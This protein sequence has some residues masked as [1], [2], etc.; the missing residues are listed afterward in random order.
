MKSLAVNVQSHEDMKK[1][2][3]YIISNYVNNDPDV[4][5]VEKLIAINTISKMILN[6]ACKK[7]LLEIMDIIGRLSNI[8]P[9]HTSSALLCLAA[10]SLGARSE[11]SN[12]EELYKIKIIDNFD[13]IFPYYQ[14][15]GTEVKTK[16]GGFIDI[17][18]IDRSSKKHVIMELKL[19]AKNCA[20]QLYGYAVD[21]ED[22]VLISITELDV[23]NKQNDIIYLTTNELDSCETMRNL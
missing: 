7:S 16:A 11:K 17:L 6:T 3:D 20:R 12:R 8:I 9:E 21:F 14:Y 10:H 19:G 2:I 18:A 4:N 23:K 1:T 13:L 22:P 5:S 15:I